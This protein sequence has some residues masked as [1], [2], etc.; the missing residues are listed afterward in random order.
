M[1]DIA[2]IGNG[3]QL[4]LA[5]PPEVIRLL[6][7]IKSSLQRVEAELRE[8][9]VRLARPVPLPEVWRRPMPSVETPT[10]TALP[11]LVEPPAPAPLPKP[12]PRG[13][14][15]THTPA[16]P[17]AAK[18]MKALMTRTALTGAGLARKLGISQTCV[19][20]VGRGVSGISFRLDEAMSKLEAAR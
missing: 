4:V 20:A 1:T 15:S 16:G 14:A 6:T 7:D 3:L 10:A 5:V 19:S 9:K 17:D 11:R 13:R 12:K 8:I 2:R 18:R